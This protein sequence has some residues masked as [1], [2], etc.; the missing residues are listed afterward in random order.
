MGFEEAKRQCRCWICHLLEAPVYFFNVSG[1][2][3]CE[4]HRDKEWASSSLI[5]LNEH[6]TWPLQLQTW[7]FRWEKP[8]DLPTREADLKS[9]DGTSWN[10]TSRFVSLCLSFFVC[11]MGIPRLPHKVNLKQRPEGIYKGTEWTWDHVRYLVNSN[12]ESMITVLEV[13]DGEKAWDWKSVTFLRLKSSNL[14]NLK[15]YPTKSSKKAKSETGGMM[16]S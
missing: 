3:A 6:R 11:K 15:K 14:L 16:V 12:M 8:V 2:L 7:W 1:I 5:P 13:G 10:W 4:L 9:G